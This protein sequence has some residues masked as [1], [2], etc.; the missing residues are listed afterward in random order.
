MVIN[1]ADEAK[2][3]KII[4]FEQGSAFFLKRGAKEMVHGDLVNAAHQYRRAYVSDPGNTECC[5]ALSEIL[6]QMQR[7]E[8][9]NQYLLLQLSMYDPAP[10]CYFGLACNYFGMRAF[11]CAADSLESYLDLDPNGFFAAD[12][13]D[14]LDFIDD[15]AA[16]RDAT[17]LITDEDYDTDE[18]C[19][20]AKRLIDSQQAAQAVALVESH[21]RRYPNS[22]RG[23]N[24]LSLAHFCNGDKKKA[25]AVNARVLEQ[26]GKNAQ[27]LANRAF[28]LYSTG[29]EASSHED[30][31]R[32]ALD[33]LEACADE[34]PETLHNRSVLELEFGRFEEAKKT[35]ASLAQQ[36]PYDENLLHK[37]GYCFFML[38][39]T[40]AAQ[41]CYRKLM[42]INPNDTVARYYYGLV[43]R[44]GSG[45]GDARA[46]WSIPYQVPFGE[47]FRRLSQINRT[48]SAS[49]AE[50]KRLWSED[51]SFRNLLLWA[52]TL[53]EQRAKKSMLNLLYT[54]GD[55]RAERELRLFLLRTDQPD[56]LKRTV[57]AMLKRLN[58]KEPYMAYLDGRWV[59]GRVNMMKLKGD[60]LPAAY[61]HV[62]QL[63]A[64][65]AE[66]E[67][68]QKAIEAG[69]ALLQTYIEQ[70]A[71]MPPRLT[72]MQETAT[73]AAL[74]YAGRASLGE[75]PDEQALCK[76]Y[77]VSGTRLRNALSRLDLPI[78]TEDE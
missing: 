10:E 24:I 49:E 56:S 45:K 40:A 4:P 65:Q 15:D 50:V 28:F 63:L 35:L 22:V 32:E 34:A 19:L 75:K 25:L 27:A 31:A 73:A 2:R 9:S 5:L 1:M 76:K 37:Q 3:G 26:D 17:G 71:G 78:L 29:S 58:A 46:R 47:M 8:E 42:R 52:L 39:E 41:A 64:A 43:K 68:A 60:K 72:S 12:A 62:L 69:V 53:P 11:D 38:G 7:F 21:L 36:V 54:F 57:F 61:E 55:E 77:R 6:G 59:Q 51:N 44:A 23:L 18:V 66:D 48:L 30:A 33:A 16:M 13:E 14:F 20:R 70:N 67:A 74:E